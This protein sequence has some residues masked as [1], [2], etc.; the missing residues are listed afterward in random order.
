MNSRRMNQQDDISNGGGGSG[1]ATIDGFA[2]NPPPS[3]AIEPA[4]ANVP[5]PSS[6]RLFGLAATFFIMMVAMELALE[7][8]SRTFSHLDYL[9]QAV[10]LLSLIHI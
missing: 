10:T 7:A 6:L 4:S 1:T 2:D 9:A 5:P 8:A 3:K